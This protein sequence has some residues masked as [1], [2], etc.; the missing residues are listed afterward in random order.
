M[1]QEVVSAEAVEDEVVDVVYSL[2]IVI[3]PIEENVKRCNHVDL[4]RIIPI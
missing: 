4:G 1:T 3:M 2:V